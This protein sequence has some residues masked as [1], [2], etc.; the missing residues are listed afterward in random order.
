M[1]SSSLFLLAWLFGDTV[2]AFASDFLGGIDALPDW[3]L[4]A[5]DR[6][7]APAHHRGAGGRVAVDGDPGAMGRARSPWHSAQRSPRSSWRL[8]ADLVD[9]DE[10]S[11]VATPDTDLGLLTSGWFPT[12]IGI[13]VLAAALTAGAPWLSRRWRRAGWVAVIGL[14]MVRIF[15][16][17]MAFGSVQAALLG[18]FAG[19]AALVAIGAP[20]RRADAESIAAGLAAV[21]LPVDEITPASV[22]ARGSTPY[23]AVMPG[24]DRLFVKVLGEDE[25]SADLHVPD[26]PQAATP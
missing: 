10:G 3:L 12:A 6:R 5:A 25:R 20:P 21:G 13:G 4:I 11:I 14:V 26:L 8:L 24:G 23:F 22:D 17:E 16:S 1:R 19:A 7:H 18:W 2:A 15:T 9:V